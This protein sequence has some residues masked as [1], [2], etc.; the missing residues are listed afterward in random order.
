MQIKRPRL[1]RGPRFCD[2]A[3]VAAGLIATLLLATLLMSALLCAATALL[4]LLVFLAIVAAL[5]VVILVTLIGV[6]HDNLLFEDLKKR[7]FTFAKV[8]RL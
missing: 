8:K 1:T 5:L 2:L 7:I 3:L 6:I 4:L